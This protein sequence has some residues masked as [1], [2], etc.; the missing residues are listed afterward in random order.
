M[1]FFFIL[2]INMIH[3]HKMPAGMNRLLISCAVINANGIII[4]NKQTNT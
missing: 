3:T 2:F 1:M 4:F